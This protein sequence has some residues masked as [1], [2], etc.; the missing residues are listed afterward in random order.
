MKATKDAQK[1]E[2]GQRLGELREAYG[3]TQIKTANMLGVSAA[4]WCNWEAGK[5]R[6]SIDAAI[7]FCEKT[8]VTLD[9][10]YRGAG[11]VP[12]KLRAPRR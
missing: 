4:A 6:I 9:W 1:Q 3:Y 5:K 8:A 12:K 11:K 10:I 2:I 7:A